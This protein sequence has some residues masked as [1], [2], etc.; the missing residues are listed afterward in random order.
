MSVQTNINRSGYNEMMAQS[1]G[2]IRDVAELTTE[3]ARA[4]SPVDTGNNRDSIKYRMESDREAI[5]FTES[6]YG[7]YLELGTVKMAARPYI[8]PAYQQAA[9]ELGG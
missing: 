6:G 9:R 7:G 5:V 4:G 2:I 1:L 8:K 3:G